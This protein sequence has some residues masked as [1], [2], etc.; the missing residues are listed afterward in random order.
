M[1]SSSSSVTARSTRALVGSPTRWCTDRRLRAAEITLFPAATTSACFRLVESIDGVANQSIFA[2]R[3]I[4]Y[5]LECPSSIILSAR[6]VPGTSEFFA[7]RLYDC[8]GVAGAMFN[9][10]S[11]A[12]PALPERPRDFTLLGASGACAVPQQGTL[13]VECALLLG[14]GGATH[15]HLKA[16]EAGRVRVST[17]GGVSLAVLP[18]EGGDAIVAASVDMRAEDRLCAVTGGAVLHDNASCCV[19]IRNLPE[20]VL[21]NTSP[22]DTPPPKRQKVDGAGSSADG[23]VGS[24]EGC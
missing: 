13:R 17:E 8:A 23:Q 9:F 1:A 7:L 16:P 14:T 2:V 18:R 6:E 24:A 10:I 3:Y 20:I 5:D 15:M 22:H 21:P 4:E 12:F 11:N 19:L